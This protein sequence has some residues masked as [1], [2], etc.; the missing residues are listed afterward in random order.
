MKRRALVLVLPL[1]AAAPL[2]AQD[3][4]NE[5]LKN[6][7]FS[8]GTTYW[9]GDCKPAGADSAT[10]YVT[11]SP[12]A[13]GIMVELHSSS[14]TKITQELR[15]KA[16]PMQAVLTVTYQVSPDFKF[17]DHNS[18]YGNCGPS[19]GFGGAEIRS[20]MGQ[21]VAFVDVPPLSR[22]SV[23]ASGNMTQVTIYDDSVSSATFAPVTA[24]SPQ[25]FTVR[26]RPPPPT[27]DSHQTLCLAFPPGSGSIT[28]TKI[29]LAT[30]SASGSSP[31][32]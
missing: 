28:I 18:D 13:G 9:H 11:S 23:A 31:N 4:S 26:L 10:D 16:A 1:L 21:V 2:F 24:Q 17:S 3:D 15:G 22:S 6:S 20:P 12:R 29:S 32:P 7:T 25:T 19:V 5:F 8:D 30:G 14:W 27:P